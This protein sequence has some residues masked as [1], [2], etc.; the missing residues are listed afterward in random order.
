MISKA[1]QMISDLLTQVNNYENEVNKIPMDKFYYKWNGLQVLHYKEYRNHL[2][3]NEQ[4]SF[5]RYAK[6]YLNRNDVFKQIFYLYA[7]ET[8][9]IEY[10]YDIDDTIVINMVKKINLNTLLEQDRS[11]TKNE[12]E[13]I[14]KIINSQLKFISNK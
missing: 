5:L 2:I 4:I 12:C 11:K 7:I 3:N 10:I 9:R 1:N 14:I 13:Q 8:G 6:Q